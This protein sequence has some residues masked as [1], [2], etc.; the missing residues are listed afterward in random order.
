MRS[1]LCATLV[2]LL[3]LPAAP[4]AAQPASRGEELELHWVVDP[5]I[6]VLAGAG[7]IGTELTKENLAPTTCQWCERNSVDDGVRNALRWGNVKAAST[8]SDLVTYGVLPV[9]TLAGGI[10]AGAADGRIGETPTNALLVVEAVAL[11]SMLNQ[12]VKFSVGRERPF[13]AALPE[14]EKSKTAKP[15]D[16]NLSFYSGHTTLAFSLVV[17]AGTIAQLRGYRA[18]PYI[19]GIGL[20]LAA[21]AAYSRIAADKHYLSDV[22]LGAAAGSAA[23]FLVPFL[24][25]KTTVVMDSGASVTF[26]PTGNG[27]AVGGTF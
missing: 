22:L 7:W 19:W 9:L 25:R 13:V 10:V 16:N 6:I 2:C 8:T 1:V 12:V 26:T 14:S 24:H 17:S 5:A 21:F 27:L 15:D 11:S 20:P 3:G 18:A 4:A 23:G